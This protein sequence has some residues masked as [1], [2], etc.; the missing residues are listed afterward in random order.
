MMDQR[1][2]LWAGLGPQAGPD[3]VDVV[4]G[5]TVEIAQLTRRLDALVDATNATLRDVASVGT[6]LLEICGLHSAE[7]TA[8]PSVAGELARASDN[9]GAEAVR[10]AMGWIRRSHTH[11]LRAALVTL[12]GWSLHLHDVVDRGWPVSSTAV[13]EALVEDECP[14]GRWLRSGH[15]DELDPDRA[16]AARPLHTEYHRT[17]S[18][19]LAAVADGRPDDARTLLESEDGHAGISRRLNRAVEAWIMVADTR[20]G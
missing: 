6:T 2:R 11:P 8:V 4:A 16:A 10:L 20:A 19:V 13:A 7:H 15:A 3:L 14:F 12:E 18:M 9:V 5:L 1:S 17:A